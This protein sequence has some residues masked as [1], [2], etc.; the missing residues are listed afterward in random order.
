M[1]YIINKLTRELIRTTSNPVNVDESVNE[2]GDVIQL[3]RI[4]DNTLPAFNSATQKLVRIS[5]D[6]DAAHTRTFSWSVVALTQAE[7][8]EIAEKAADTNRRTQ[9]QNM[10]T[11]LENGT[12][13]A[14]QQRQVLAFLLRREL[15]R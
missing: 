9:A 8:D 11:A 5:T 3:K 2:W 13:T 12:I 14:A 15:K 7:L 6:N 4:D 1:F 10:L